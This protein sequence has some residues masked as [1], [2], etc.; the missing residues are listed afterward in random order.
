L[1]SKHLVPT[2]GPV[3][4]LSEE[5]SWIYSYMNHYIIAI[6]KINCHLPYVGGVVMVFGYKAISKI[7]ALQVPEYVFLA[8]FKRLDN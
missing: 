1:V 8:L 3:P 2:A 7:D 4:K 5:P 6:W